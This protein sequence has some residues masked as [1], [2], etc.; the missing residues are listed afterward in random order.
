[1]H[2]NY[3]TKQ[4]FRDPA[5]LKKELLFPWVCVA[6]QRKKR[7]G[8]IEFVLLFGFQVRKSDDSSSFPNAE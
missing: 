8:V 7:E 6:V 5:F 4:K 3:G 1:M 2:Q